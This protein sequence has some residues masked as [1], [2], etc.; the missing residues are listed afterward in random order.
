L[1]APAGAGGNQH[2]DFAVGS[3]TF[4]DEK[5]DDALGERLFS[6]I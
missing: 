3:Y 4:D 1:G 2:G 5:F 6:F